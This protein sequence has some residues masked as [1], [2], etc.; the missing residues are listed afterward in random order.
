M[1]PE[2]VDCAVKMLRAAME[3]ARRL[4]P[5]LGLSFGYIGNLEFVHP[6]RDDRCW[7]VFSKLSTKP[8]ATGCNI[9]WARA[10]TSELGSLA[11]AAALGDVFDWA[12]RQA[13]L[14][15]D[16]KIH[17]VCPGSWLEAEIA[18]AAEWQ[19]RTRLTAGL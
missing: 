17:Q 6:R 7:S 9:S 3:A 16:G 19:A 5:Q 14:L 8:C 10:A 18:H 2:R 12:D 4:H 1:T 15:A 11:V 13:I